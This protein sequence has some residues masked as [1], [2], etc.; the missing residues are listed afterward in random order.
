MKKNSLAYN[1]EVALSNDPSLWETVGIPIPGDEA[2]YGYHYCLGQ[3]TF[4]KKLQYEILD[5]P[6][7]EF[8]TK[9]DNFFRQ[10]SVRGGAV[11][12]CPKKISR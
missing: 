7:D 11:A 9:A 12:V 3:D 2:I 8:T 10:V 6:D 4:F 1:L 5:T